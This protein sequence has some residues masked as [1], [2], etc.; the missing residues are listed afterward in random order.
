MVGQHKYFVVV[1]QYPTQGGLILQ[2]F[3]DRPIDTLM[4]SNIRH[5][6][7][8]MMMSTN[9]SPQVHLA[10]TLLSA[11]GMG[12]Q[13][14]HRKWLWA[15]FNAIR[16][17]MLTNNCCNVFIIHARGHNGFWGFV[18]HFLHSTVCSGPSKSS[19][20]KPNCLSFKLTISVLFFRAA[21]IEHIKKVWFSH[22][23]LSLESGAGLIRS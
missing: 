22:N 20:K 15:I 6:S 23:P 11:S 9:V 14:L 16:N 12:L 10:E 18:Y 2:T 1:F 17:T 5:H 13:D 3:R 8:R 7:V 19:L 21:E 4:L